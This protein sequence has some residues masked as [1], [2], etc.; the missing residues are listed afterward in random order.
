L[1]RR[2]RLAGDHCCRESLT[3]TRAD[4]LRVDLV[5]SAQ[6]AVIPRRMHK[7][8]VTYRIRLESNLRLP[9]AFLDSASVW[10]L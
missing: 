5:R 10:G 2:A 4:Q 1:S 6:I 7:C 8:P 9:V 3:A